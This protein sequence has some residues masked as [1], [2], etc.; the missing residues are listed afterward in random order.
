MK[1]RIIS[2]INQKGGVGKT[3]VV[4]NIAHGL[5]KAGKKV[6][7]ID[8]DPQGNLTSAFGYDTTDQNTLLEIITDQCTVDDAIVSMSGID[9][10]P[11][12]IMLTGGE[13]QL[14]N[15]D[16]REWKIKEK[17]ADIADNY[18]YVLLDCQP[19]LGMLPFNAL[20]A[21][22]EVFVVMVPEYFSAAGI[23]LLHQTME[24]VKKPYYNPNLK[25]TGVVINKFKKQTQ[26]HKSVRD[27]AEQAFGNVVF[28]TDIR[29]SIAIAESVGVHKPVSEYKTGNGNND[30]EALLKEIIAQEVG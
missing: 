23:Q 29:D 1:T 7:C 12:D 10:I 26:L 2:I 20:I 16:G 28:N 24:R 5:K 25:I 4:F 9:L 6:L 11:A 22:K 8:T 30:F 27:A 13:M 14:I 3:T 19:S 17:I 18:D 21:S 15:M